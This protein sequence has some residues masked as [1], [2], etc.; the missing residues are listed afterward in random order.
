MPV[1][2]SEIMDLALE[3][4]GLAEAPADSGVIVPGDGIEKIM[5]GVDIGPA[6]L[7]LARELDVDLVI[8]HHPAAG[9]PAARG[10]AVMTDHIRR[11]VEAGIPINKAQKALQ[12]RMDEV[13]RRL[14]AVNHD[15]TAS[16]AR[17]LGIPFMAIHTPADILAENTVQRHLDQAL[18]GM[19]RATL[20]DVIEALNRLPEYQKT[21]ARPV[22]RA[23]SEKDY[24]GRVLVSMSGG[25]GGG[26]AVLKAYFEAGVGTLVEMHMPEPDLKEVKEQGIGNVVIAGH[27]ASDSVGLNRIL[28]ALEEK[29]MTVIRMSGVIDPN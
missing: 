17:L 2:T 20:G 14:H 26:A 7:M 1:N 8:T 3:L 29:G 6:E 25:T 15:R 5:A 19:P 27:M 23:G 13:E 16:A 4:A 24:A 18:D 22:I 28:A 9:S 11:M 12:K 10:Y 21:L